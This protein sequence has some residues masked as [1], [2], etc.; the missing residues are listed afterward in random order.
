MKRLAAL[1]IVALIATIQPATAHA[2]PQRPTEYVVSTTPGDTPEGIEV[3]RNGTTNTWILNP[4]Q[5]LAS[6]TKYTASLRSGITDAATNPLAV[7]TWSFP[8]AL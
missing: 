6:N 5:N 4:D 1:T 2:V 8:T 3:T 7:T